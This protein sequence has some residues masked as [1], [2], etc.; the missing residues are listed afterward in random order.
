MCEPLEKL[1]E[2]G[3]IFLDGNQKPFLVRMNGDTPW[4]FRLHPDNQWVSV[5]P[6]NQTAVWA[7]YKTK[8]TDELDRHYRDLTGFH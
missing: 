1:D 4:F 5:R 2:K 7:A 3:F 6:A 8:V